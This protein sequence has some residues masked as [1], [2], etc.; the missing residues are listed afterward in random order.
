MRWGYGTLAAWSL[1]ALVLAAC[2]TATTQTGLAA[3]GESLRQVGLQ[4]I[5]VNQFYV[6]GCTDRTIGKSDCATFS[7]FGRRFRGEYPAA[8]DAWEAARAAN[9]A[10]SE[11]A[12]RVVIARLAAELSE[13]AVT[14]L[15]AS[16]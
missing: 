3:S 9:D 6:Q 8:V 11:Q 2:S 13:V 14:A 1:A 4:F 16:K 10:A 12:A 15:Q 5:A 7:G